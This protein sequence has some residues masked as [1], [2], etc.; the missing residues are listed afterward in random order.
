MQ[1]E[2]GFSRTAYNIRLETTPAAKDGQGK[3]IPGKML[4][5]ASLN[6]GWGN[7]LEDEIDLE[8]LL[9]NMNGNL[10]TRFNYEAIM[11]QERDCM[12][13]LENVRN[14]R[15][16]EQAKPGPVNIFQPQT[17]ADQQH[18][19]IAEVKNEDGS[20]AERRVELDQYCKSC[21]CAIRCKSQ[22]DTV[23]GAVLGE[24]Y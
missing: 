15:L 16:G 24:N 14:I 11:R 3:E 23:I 17:R 18:E 19:L 10:T 9:A 22:S 13:F 1:K 21:F 4:L 7:N 2:N 5:K 20:W 12:E 8:V 6:N